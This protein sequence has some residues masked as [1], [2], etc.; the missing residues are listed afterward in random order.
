MKAKTAKKV[1][2]LLAWIDDEW[3]R[4]STRMNDWFEELFAGNDRSLLFLLAGVMAIVSAVPLGIH[5]ADATNAPTRESVMYGGIFG[6]LVFTTPM[7]VPFIYILLLQFFGSIGRFVGRLK[8]ATEVKLKELVQI[9][10][11][12]DPEAEAGQLSFPEPRKK[13]NGTTA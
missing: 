10:S 2:F 1:L 9:E 8:E 13:A 4:L 12:L 6:L 3:K 7:W 5:F 11:N